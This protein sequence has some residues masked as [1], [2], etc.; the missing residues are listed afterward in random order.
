MNAAPTMDLIEIRKAGLKA[1]RNVLGEDG[2]E[3]FLMMFS[4]TGDFTKERHELPQPTM[5]EAV[6]G[7]NRLQEEG[8]KRGVH[9]M[10]AGEL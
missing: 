4:G 3:M 6:A 5:E 8:L 7:I 2:R 10:N 1:L 9:Y